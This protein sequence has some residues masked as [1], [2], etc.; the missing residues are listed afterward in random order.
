MCCSRP[1]ERLSENAR[2]AAVM[3]Q[4]AKRVISVSEMTATLAFGDL[5]AKK[6]NLTKK[7]AETLLKDGK[8]YAS[9]IFSEKTGKTYDAYIV[10]E[11]DGQRSA[12]KLEFS[13]ENRK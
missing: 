1:E 5:A 8:T 6:I 2:A 4:R 3:L 12:Y 10:L 11:D 13:K 7:M 9:G